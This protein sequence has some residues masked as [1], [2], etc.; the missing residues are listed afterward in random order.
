MIIQST[1][2]IS[3]PVWTVWIGMTSTTF[4]AQRG[5]HFSST[6]EANAD[7]SWFGRESSENFVGKILQI[8]QKQYFSFLRY[9]KIHTDRVAALITCQLKQK[10]GLTQVSFSADIFLDEDTHTL[11]QLRAWIHL[12][13]DRLPAIAVKIHIDNPT[14]FFM[15]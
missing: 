10:D 8:R 5:G 7:I 3:S 15:A 6:W 9:E 11:S 14:N 2:E 1:A 12:Q 13:L 4:H